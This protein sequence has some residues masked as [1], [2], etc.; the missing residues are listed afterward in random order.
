MGDGSED[1]S[2]YGAYAYARSSPVPFRY[3]SIWASLKDVTAFAL[4]ARAAIARA[5]EKC[6]ARNAKASKRK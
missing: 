3:V 5:S 4:A 1:K 6:I 2:A